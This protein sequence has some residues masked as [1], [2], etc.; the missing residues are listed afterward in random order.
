MKRQL[1]LLTGLSV[2]G[3]AS[4]LGGGDDAPRQQGLFFN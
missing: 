1:L 3:E 4:Y 2:R